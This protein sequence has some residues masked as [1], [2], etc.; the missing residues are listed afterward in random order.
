MNGFYLI[1]LLYAL[2]V[3]LVVLLD[4]LLNWLNNREPPSDSES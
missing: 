2:I 4:R 3:P 1:L